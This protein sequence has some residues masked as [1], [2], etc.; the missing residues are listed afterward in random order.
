MM[1]NVGWAAAAAAERHGVGV[2]HRLAGGNCQAECSEENNHFIFL[3]EVKRK[4]G[5]KVTASDLR[6]RRTRLCQR[7]FL[8]LATP[9]NLR[10]PC[11]S[12]AS[13]R[14]QL[15]QFLSAQADA[16]WSGKAVGGGRVVRVVA[17][18]AA[19]FLQGE[20]C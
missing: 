15:G 10:W 17:L 1:E 12:S 4:R 2:E 5:H 9:P 18:G 6:L 19:D 16:S 13:P 3:C 20:F 11:L 7:V 8:T 14:I